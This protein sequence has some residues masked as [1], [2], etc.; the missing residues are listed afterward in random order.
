MLRELLEHV[1]VNLCTCVSNAR[2]RTVY[3][4]NPYREAVGG[5]GSDL[6]KKMGAEFFD[7]G[8]RT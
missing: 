7:R 5:W 6:C 8:K 3:V 1:G 2:E 4:R